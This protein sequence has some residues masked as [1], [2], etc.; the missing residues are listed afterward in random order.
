MSNFLR[1]FVLIVIVPLIPIVM[2]LLFFDYLRRFFSRITKR[3]L[4]S[5]L[6][7]MQHSSKGRRKIEG[8]R[9]LMGLAIVDTVDRLIGKSLLK[10]EVSQT[11]VRL[12]ARALLKSRVSNKAVRHFNEQYGCD[13]PWFLTLSPGHACNLGCEGC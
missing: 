11:S 9:T 4:A 3:W 10:P 6:L 8:Q 7:E 12:W 13:P 2:R 1:K 5:N